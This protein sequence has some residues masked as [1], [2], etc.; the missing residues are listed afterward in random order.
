MCDCVRIAGTNHSSMTSEV[1]TIFGSA[2]PMQ[3]ASA[4]PHAPG[5]T[6]GSDRR[7]Q[8]DVAASA[9]RNACLRPRAKALLSVVGCF[10]WQW[11]ASSCSMGG[12]RGMR[13]GF[14][15]DQPNFGLPGLRTVLVFFPFGVGSAT[16][17][18]RAPTIFSHVPAGT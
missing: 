6:N 14:D 10:R 3:A 2:S 18:T 4:D 5:A 16:L 13:R 1:V 11:I 12:S 7:R 8:E 9:A 17:T 15:V